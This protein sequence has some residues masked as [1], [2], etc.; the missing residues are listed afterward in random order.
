MKLRTRKV[1]TSLKI[2]N[3]GNDYCICSA[4][5]L[6]Y[7]V[8]KY[9]IFQASCDGLCVWEDCLQYAGKKAYPVSIYL[10]KVKNGN[11]RTMF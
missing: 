4:T 6:K 9:V 11:T 3:T 1:N 10:Y 5:Q 8:L 7:L 2:S